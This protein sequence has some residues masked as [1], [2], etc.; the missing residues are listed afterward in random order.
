MKVV[1]SAN[2]NPACPGGRLAG[3]LSLTKQ[4]PGD[5]TINPLGGTAPLNS[6]VDVVPTFVLPS[7]GARGTAVVVGAV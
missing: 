5:W 6:V 3:P 1:G 4:L 2:Q 7:M